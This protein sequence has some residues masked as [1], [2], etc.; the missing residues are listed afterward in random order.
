MQ[1]FPLPRHLF[2]RAASHPSSM[3]CGKMTCK[4]KILSKNNR[5]GVCKA[6]ITGMVF[7]FL[8]YLYSTSPILNREKMFR[9]SSFSEYDR[10]FSLLSSSY[11][12]RKRQD[13]SAYCLREMS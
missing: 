6:K 4:I 5:Y 2:G 13:F 7:F 1:A 8:L 11:C 10:G 12:R 9:L 3:P